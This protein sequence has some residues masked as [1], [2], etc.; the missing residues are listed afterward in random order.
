MCI[1]KFYS[2][3]IYKDNLQII[4]SLS[5]SYREHENL[6]IVLYIHCF[7]IDKLANFSTKKW[8]SFWSSSSDSWTY[9]LLLNAVYLA[10]QTAEYFM[11]IFAA[12]YINIVFKNVTGQA[13]HRLNKTAELTSAIFT[14]ICNSVTVT[15]YLV[16]M[17]LWNVIINVNGKLLYHHISITHS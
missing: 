7:L 10:C 9:I 17:K 16:N 5:E 11:C 6:I 1:Y 3:H 8:K 12:V 14:Y 4:K 2:V 13:G 15:L